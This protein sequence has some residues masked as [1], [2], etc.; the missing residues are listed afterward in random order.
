MD[1]HTPVGF[2]KPDDVARYGGSIANSS[3]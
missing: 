1:L 3:G 2:D